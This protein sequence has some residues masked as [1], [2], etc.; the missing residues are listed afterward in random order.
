MTSFTVRQVSFTGLPGSLA[1]LASPWLL[2]SPFIKK[3]ANPTIPNITTLPLQEANPNRFERTE[4]THYLSASSEQA[5]CS[6]KQAKVESFLL[7]A[8]RPS[9]LRQATLTR[10]FLARKSR[11][12]QAEVKYRALHS[13]L[14]LYNRK[15]EKLRIQDAVAD[16]LA[17]AHL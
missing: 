12:G 5:H 1:N 3:P 15:A 14:P 10:D 8:C 11:S 2:P 16:R 9:R 4:S 13:S 6:R 7:Q 17:G